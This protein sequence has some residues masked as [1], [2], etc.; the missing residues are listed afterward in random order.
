MQ[1]EE[2]LENRFA[3]TP[4]EMR[5]TTGVGRNSIYAALNSGELKGKKIGRKKWIIPVT[6]V[7]RWINEA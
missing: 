2:K 1:L 7:L 5:A 6:E 3:I 4:D